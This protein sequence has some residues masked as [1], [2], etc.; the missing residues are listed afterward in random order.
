MT[1]QAQ[2]IWKELTP[3]FRGMVCWLKSFMVGFAIIL[4]MS[5]VHGTQHI[6]TLKKLLPKPTMKCFF[7]HALPYHCTSTRSITEVYSQLLQCILI[8]THCKRRIPYQ[9]EHSLAGN[10]H[11]SLE[12][13]VPTQMCIAANTIERR[14][15]HFMGNLIKLLLFF[16]LRKYFLYLYDFQK[17]FRTISPLE[18]FLIHIFRER[19][20]TS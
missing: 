12:P 14:H 5:L 16:F 10:K 2:R 3:S 15:R 6:F 20:T 7:Y 11:R 4:F 13:S 9:C 1:G 8:A 17:Y 19:I 18:R